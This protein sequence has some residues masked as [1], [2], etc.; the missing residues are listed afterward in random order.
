MTT[1]RS[2]L[3]IGIVLIALAAAACRRETPPDAADPAAAPP[4]VASLTPAP[5][6]VIPKILSVEP[7]TIFV[8]DGHATPGIY[9]VLYEITN[10]DR[11]VDAEVRVHAPGL[12][13]VQQ[14]PIAQPAA[15]A[16][17][18]IVVDP[19]KKDFGPTLAFRARCP[20][21]NT[22]WRTLGSEPLSAAEFSEPVLRIASVSPD[23]ISLDRALIAGDGDIPAG[24]GV[25]VSVRGPLLTA[26]C[27]LEASVNGGPIELH[28]VFPADKHLRGLV[29]YRDIGNRY[30]STRYLE[31]QLVVR[32]KG[33]AREAIK[34]IH[35]VD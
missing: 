19:T 32:G 8:R 7:A 30:V 34:R 31:L 13:R 20:G 29:L 22:D 4:P 5:T 28:N 2:R 6:E 16:N 33:F 15:R 21:G 35:F 25:E 23:R 17:I 3:A 11:V 27:T 1:R 9:N 14:M 10:V 12:G 18:S 24:A 26:Q